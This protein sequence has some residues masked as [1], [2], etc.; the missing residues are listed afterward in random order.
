M[1]LSVA[2]SA[3]KAVQNAFSEDEEDLLSNAPSHQYLDDPGNVMS[4]TDEQG[5]DMEPRF[6]DIGKRV[7]PEY[8]EVDYG[9]F[10]KVRQ[11]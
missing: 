10:W 1:N 2:V 6:E 3:V 9:E 7:I 5:A 11:T 4:Y 8:V